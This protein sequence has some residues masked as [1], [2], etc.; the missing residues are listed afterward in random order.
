MGMRALSEQLT[1]AFSFTILHSPGSIRE[2]M[3]LTYVG[4]ALTF[5]KRFLLFHTCTFS[6]PSSLKNK[7]PII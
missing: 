3:Q 7:I 2:Q 5:Q 6:T 1:Y 4:I